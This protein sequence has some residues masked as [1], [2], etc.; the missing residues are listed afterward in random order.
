MIWLQCGDAQLSLLACPAPC[1]V[2]S[3]L[4]RSACR[5]YMALCC[6]PCRP[7]GVRM[8]YGKPN[9]AAGAHSQ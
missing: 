1:N 4:S 3:A 5:A 6:M 8:Q 7:Q 9:G 2:S